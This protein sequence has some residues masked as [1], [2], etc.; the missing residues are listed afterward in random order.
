MEDSSVSQSNI[1]LPY[2]LTYLIQLL[3][4]FFSGS[5]QDDRRYRLEICFGYGI[6]LSI[7]ILTIFVEFSTDKCF[8]IKPNFGD[9][10]CFFAGKY[11]FGMIDDQDS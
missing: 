5:Q 2:L 10:K 7:S 9:E 4:Y 6:P 11:S 3:T 1:Y 8:P